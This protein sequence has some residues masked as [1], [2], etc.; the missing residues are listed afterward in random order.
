MTNI[1]DIDPDMNHTL[2]RQS[3]N[4]CEMYNFDTFISKFAS[5]H[6]DLAVLTFNIRS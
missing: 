4:S 3:E 5:Q 1:S 2:F 6:S